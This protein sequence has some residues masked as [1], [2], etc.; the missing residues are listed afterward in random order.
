MNEEIEYAEM[1][2]IPVSTVNVVRKNQRRKRVKKQETVVENPQPTT[3]EVNA[4]PLKDSVIA[5]VNNRLSEQ[6][7]SKQQEGFE[8]ESIPEN[9]TENTVEESLDFD[10]IPER[11]DTLRLYSDE[12][13]GNWRESLYPQD[14][15]PKTQNDVGRYALNYKNKKNSAL[16]IALNAEFIAACALCGAIFL[17]NVFMPNSAINT[18]FRS[19]HSASEAAQT[20]TRHYTDFTLSPVVSELSDAELSLSPA[21]ILS[22]T[23]AGCVYAVANGTVSNVL[24]NSDGTYT[25]KISHSD[26]FTGVFN[27]LD[28][29]YYTEGEQVLSNVPLGY[30]NGE[31]EVQVTMYS[32]GALL[33]CFQLTEENCLAWVE[34]EE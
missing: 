24:Q 31:T 19:I 15:A 13:M 1:L 5:Q 21:G 23:D 12:E 27:G 2:E 26:N 34:A 6:P 33:N 30:S 28:F 22:F 32:D 9:N 10:P 18:F 25:V 11:I 7:T 3:V 16:K 4:S 20:D 29:V 8:E 14:F 17:T